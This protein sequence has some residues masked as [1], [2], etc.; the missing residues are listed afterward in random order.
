MVDV[1]E[2]KESFDNDS[3]RVTVDRYQRRQHDDR[4]ACLILPRDVTL[5]SVQQQLDHFKLTVRHGVVKRRVALQNNIKLKVHV[6]RKFLQCAYL[7]QAAILTALG[8]D[9]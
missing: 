2:L 5:P 3:I 8:V 6:T 4:T 7:H 1:S 9:L